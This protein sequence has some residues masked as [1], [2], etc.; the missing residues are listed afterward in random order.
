VLEL[1]DGDIV[2][3]GSKYAFCT[4]ITQRVHFGFEYKQMDKKFVM[5]ENQKTIF[6]ASSSFFVYLLIKLH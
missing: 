5:E 2:N 3:G 1:L 4:Q 6:L